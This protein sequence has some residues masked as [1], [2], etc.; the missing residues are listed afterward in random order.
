MKNGMVKQPSLVDISGVLHVRHPMRQS[1]T[2]EMVYLHWST[3]LQTKDFT[4]TYG[5]IENIKIEETRQ[6]S[7]RY[8]FKR[9]Y[10]EPYRYID[11]VNGPRTKSTQTDIEP[12]PCPKVRKGINTQY[13]FGVWEKELK[14]GWCKA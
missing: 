8:C 2:P 9:H 11:L 1:L 5:P 12:I 4:A 6:Y 10:L 14:T 13:R 7:G 3:G